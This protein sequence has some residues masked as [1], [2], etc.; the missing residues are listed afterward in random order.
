MEVEIKGISYFYKTKG[1]GDIVLL[2]HGNPDSADLWDDLMPLLADQY[3]CIAPD[4]PGFG[5]SG[6]A[7]SF[8]ASLENTAEWVSDFLHALEITEKVCII[9][10]DVGGFFGI[11]FAIQYPERVWSLTI[12]NTVF[13]P[14]YKWHFWARV[15]RT[16]ILGEL[17]TLW[18]PKHFFKQE[19]RRGGPGL[20]EEF[21]EKTYQHLSPKMQ[22]TVLKL[23][24]AFDLEVFEAWQADYTKMTQT[25]PLLVVWGDLDKYIPLHFGF[26]EKFAQG[27]SVHHLENCGHW[28][29]AEKPEELT[30]LWLE[31]VPK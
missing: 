1:E 21:L 16:P 31:F 29:P 25:I 14:E 7:K 26:A 3:R 23:Y 5:R 18:T 13:F 19:L 17:S 22:K 2:L 12:T 6:I 30:K 8:E 4:L 11:P 20:S 27:N 24:R 28:V 9:L 10:H 15:W